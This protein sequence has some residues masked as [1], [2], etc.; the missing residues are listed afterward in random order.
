[1]KKLLIVVDMQND[2]VFGSLGT[3]EA[4]AILPNVKAKIEQFRSQGAEIVFTRDTHDESY[5]CTQEG[6]N[7]PILH[8]QK[9]TE[10]W[11]IIKD[12]YA[13]EKIFDK[14]VFGSLE[15]AKYVALGGYEEITLIGVCTD[16]CVLSNAVLI[17]AE[18]PET[19]IKVVA[20]CCAG[21]TPSAHESAIAVLSSIQVEIL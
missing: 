8:C 21:V 17:K 19:P 15:L 2:F 7:L 4:R 12:L 16:I 9:G 18:S 13:G 11:Q 14:A 1:M 6:K 5:L 10:G 3:G 20:N